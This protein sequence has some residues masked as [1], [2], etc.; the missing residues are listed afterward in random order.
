M[1]KMC[2]I[3]GMFIGSSAGGWLGAQMGIFMMVIL[4]AVGAAAGFYYGRRLI[5]DFIDR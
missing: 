3:A 4:S 2:A 5:Q 1:E